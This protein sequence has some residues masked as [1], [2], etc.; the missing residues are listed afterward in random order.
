M[1]PQIFQHYYILLLYFKLYSNYSKFTILYRHWTIL[2]MKNLS[3]REIVQDSSF[4]FEWLIGVSVTITLKCW[5]YRK[6]FVLRTVPKLV[7]VVQQRSPIFRKFWHGSRLFW[8]SYDIQSLP[9]MIEDLS[10][11]S[12]K[13]PFYYFFVKKNAFCSIRQGLAFNSSTVSSRFQC[14]FVHLSTNSLLVRND[15]KENKSG[16]SS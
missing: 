16:T 11:F 2:K 13:F 1:V 7:L 10:K 15:V 5:Y 12:K 4:A 8:Q 14:S 6:I 3:P 9:L